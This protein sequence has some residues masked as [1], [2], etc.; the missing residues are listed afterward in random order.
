[1]GNFPY[2]R[3]FLNE[4]SYDQRKHLTQKV[5][6]GYRIGTQVAYKLTPKLTL[7]GVLLLN[8]H[9]GSTQKMMI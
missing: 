5:K 3:Y 4:S 9:S 2:F 7:W 8:P 6:N 1:M